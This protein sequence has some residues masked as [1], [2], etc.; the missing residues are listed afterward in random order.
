MAGVVDF[1]YIFRRSLVLTAEYFGT[2]ATMTDD[3]HLRDIVQRRLDEK[4][5]L[6]HHS[7]CVKNRSKKFVIFFYF[8]GILILN[9]ATVV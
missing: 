7:F 9:E 4:L 8:A 2:E 5:V 1:G 6:S 3:L